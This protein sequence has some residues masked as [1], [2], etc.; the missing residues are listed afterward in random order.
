MWDRAV[1][2]AEENN[3]KYSKSA[4]EGFYAS[5]R[6]RNMKKKVKVNGRILI[7]SFRSS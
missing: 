4:F 6:S 5:S 2:G 7:I 3:F 1:V